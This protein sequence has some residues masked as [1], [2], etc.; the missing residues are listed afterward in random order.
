MSFTENQISDFDEFFHWLKTGGLRARRNEKNLRKKIFAALIN[1]DIETNNSYRQF[2]KS[3]ELNQ[4]ELTNMDY[5]KMMEKAQE[6]KK[7]INWDELNKSINKEL[8]GYA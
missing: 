3:K 5:L 2:I 8:R 1:N 7:E 4:G 6:M